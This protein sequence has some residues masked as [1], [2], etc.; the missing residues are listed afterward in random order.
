MKFR[1]GFVSNSSSSSFL[2][3]FLTKPRSWKVIK[4]MLFG[5]MDYVEY[6]GGAFSTIEIA[7]RVFKDLT[8]KH[9]LG[10]RGLLEEIRGGYFPGRPNYKWNDRPSNKLKKQFN[11]QFPQY[12]GNYCAVGKIKET[13]AKE[14]SAKIL[15]AHQKEHD[16]HQQARENAANKYL[17]NYV[18]PKFRGLKVYALE[19]GDHDRPD[20]AIEHG[21]VFENVPHI[22]I[23]HH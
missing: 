20:A 16:E 17:S 21:G 8:G 2:I 14:L 3:G 10:K 7:K 12:K 5:N 9:P 23:S 15:A 19:Y 18:E 1:I 11:D 6:F 22:Q 13:M 4:E